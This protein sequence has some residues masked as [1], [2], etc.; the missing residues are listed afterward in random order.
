MKIYAK[1]NPVQTLTE[2]T[3]NLITASEKI[4]EVLGNNLFDWYLFKVVLVLHDLGKINAKFQERIN[5]SIETGEKIS[6]LDGE[7]PHNLLSGGFI[8]AILAQVKCTDS[9]KHLIYKAV[10][11]HHKHFLYYLEQGYALDKI[12]KALF[13]NVHKHYGVN[14]ADL[15]KVEEFVKAELN[16]DKVDLINPD[17]DFFEYYNEHFVSESEEDKKLYLLLKGFLNLCDHLASG[18]QDSGS[19]YYFSQSE[20]SAIDQKLIDYL[21]NEN[22]IKNPV[23]TDFQLKVKNNQN[24]NILTEA[25]TGSGKTIADHL[26]TGSRKFYLVP[27]RISAE[28]FYMQSE[29]IY[30]EGKVG[31]LHGD[32]FLYVDNDDSNGICIEA[33]LHQLTK[34]LA[35]P[36]IVATIDQ[37]ATAIFKYPN[38]EKLLVSLI[39]SKITVDEVHLLS[40]KMLALFVNLATFLTKQNWNIKF[41]LMTATLPD[42]FRDKLSNLIELENCQQTVDTKKAV[43]KTA[44]KSVKNKTDKIKQLKIWLKDHQ[45]ALIIVNSITHL[46][47]IYKDLENDFKINVLHS[48]FKFDDKQKKYQAILNND[49]QE[50]WLTTQLVEVA[51][52]IDFPVV[53][54]ELS[55]L[56]SMIQRMGR[57]NRHDVNG[58][59][60]GQ[61]Y[62]FKTDEEKLSKINEKIYDKICLEETAKLLK[63]DQIFTQ[64]DRKKM[65]DDYFKNDKIV[66]QFTKE[67]EEA[68]YEIRKIYAL[69]PKTD[70][71]KVDLIMQTEP[72]LNLTET[73]LQAQKLFRDGE[74]DV[75]VIL[76][77]DFDLTKKS[78]FKAIMKKTISINS[79]TLFRLKKLNL[80]SSYQDS[81]IVLNQAVKYNDVIGLNIDE[82]DNFL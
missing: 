47:E 58:E 28:A 53:I 55:P 27:T 82:P 72:H 62:I 44:F 45:R 40:P 25:F 43:I 4:K 60:T 32:S 48:R 67:F 70:L 64:P 24:K 31:I 66:K 50:I 17:F 73:K 42:I 80:V 37:L 34:N 56:E 30:G 77:Q 74:I 26:F 38:Y 1:S 75:K 16:I 15:V 68:E 61:F 18:D 57:C 14:S 33:G 9:Q 59:K 29:K 69:N 35:M 79:G 81:L 7:I 20:I 51:L 49:G 3:A 13:D 52:D 6:L 19:S 21:K 23:F 46:L 12:Q 2:H 36:Y 39:N 63:K 5:K 65:L 71:S 22:K 8:K 10:M 54:S 78:G 11:L 76:F 41:H